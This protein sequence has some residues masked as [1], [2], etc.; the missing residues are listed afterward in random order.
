MQ[1]SEK[2]IEYDFI[3]YN[4]QKLSINSVYSIEPCWNK[5]KTIEQHP[6]PSDFLNQTIMEKPVLGVGFK[7]FFKRTPSTQTSEENSIFYNNPD[8]E[9]ESLLYNYPEKTYFKTNFKKLHQEYNPKGWKERMLEKHPKIREK[10]EGETNQIKVNPRKALYG[11]DAFKNLKQDLTDEE[12]QKLQEGLKQKKLQNLND[13]FNE[14]DQESKEFEDQYLENK[15][16]IQEEVTLRSNTDSK[17]PSYVNKEKPKQILKLNQDKLQELDT[18]LNELDQESLNQAASI[19]S[20]NKFLFS[21]EM[22]D[23]QSNLQISNELEGIQNDLEAS[24]VMTDIEESALDSTSI[25]S[26]IGLLAPAGL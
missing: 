12:I 18:F 24:D 17:I 10:P 25:E 3:I 16:E 22:E 11:E 13:F 4:N 7:D 14:T 1:Y 20:E 2:P 6:A 5:I 9:E 23:A 21:D 15:A 8:S 19:D 26:V